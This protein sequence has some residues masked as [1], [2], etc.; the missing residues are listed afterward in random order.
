MKQN[1]IKVK[2]KHTIEMLTNLGFQK[3]NE[4]NGIVTFLNDANLRFSNEVDKSKLQYS[5]MLTF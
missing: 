5:N 1:F 2:D 4:E 3:I